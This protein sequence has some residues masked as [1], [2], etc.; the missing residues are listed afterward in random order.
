MRTQYQAM[1]DMAK[2]SRQGVK[3]C[4]HFCVKPRSELPFVF[5]VHKNTEK[6]LRITKASLLGHQNIQGM[7][8]CTLS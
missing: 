6:K 8:G 7:I 5:W 1:M 4:E 3:I 2:N